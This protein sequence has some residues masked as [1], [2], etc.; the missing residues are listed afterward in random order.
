MDSC[1]TH[2]NELINNLKIYKVIEK[3]VEN[4]NMPINP[5]LDILF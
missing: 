4:K 5:I 3:K 2:L 1:A